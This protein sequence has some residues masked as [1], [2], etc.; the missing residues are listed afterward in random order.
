M[1]IF[2]ENYPFLRFCG[3]HVCFGNY[4]KCCKIKQSEELE[5]ISQSEE[6]GTNLSSSKNINDNDQNLEVDE[7]HNSNLT[8]LSQLQK[9]LFKKR[10]TSILF[11][12]IFQN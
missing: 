1:I 3:C 9:Q 11:Y 6:S 8:V 5:I 7:S 2:Q 12:G 10:V 4:I